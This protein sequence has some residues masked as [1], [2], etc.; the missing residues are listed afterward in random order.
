ML[1]QLEAELRPTPLNHTRPA[2]SSEPG[3]LPWLAEPAHRR[4]QGDEGELSLS[5]SPL[6]K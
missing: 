5:K 1:T 6:E 2:P 4:A 3:W